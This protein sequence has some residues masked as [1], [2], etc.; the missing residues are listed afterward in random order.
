MKM[1]NLLLTSIAI[2][3]LA[4]ISFGQTLPSYVP[5]DGLV[6]WWPFNGNANDESINN[7]NGQTMGDITLVED[8]FGNSNSAYHFDGIDDHI[9]VPHNVSLNSYPMTIN[10][11]MKSTGDA[12]DGILLTK[13]CCADWQGWDIQVSN[14]QG[15]SAL[16]T[17]EYLRGGCLGLYQWYCGAQLQ[18]YHKAFDDIWHMYT[19]RIDE[20]GAS[21][22]WDGQLVGSQQWIGSPG[23]INNTLDLMMGKGIQDNR[24]YFGKLDDIGIWNRALTE[25]EVTSLYSGSSLGVSEVSQSNLFSVFPNPAQSLINVNIEANLVGSVFTIYDNIGKAVKTGKLNSLNTTIDVNDLSG[26]IYSF[27]VG[28]NSKQTF[29]VIKE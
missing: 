2:F 12:T 16:F 17:R 6:G 1:K 11:W 14:A 3:G 10:L 24:H 20:N 21:I 9:M 4:T 28:G 5:S 7:N 27:N 29:K 19:F 13:Y 26:G 8:R 25:Q 18:Q 23:P 15:D 22:F